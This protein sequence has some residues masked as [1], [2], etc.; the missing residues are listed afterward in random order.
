EF[1]ADRFNVNYPHYKGHFARVVTYKTEYAQS[2][3]DDFSAKD[4][5]PHIALS[6]DM[7]DTGI[8]V[9]EVV[10]LV[11]F[12]VV[13]SKTKFWQMLGRGTRLCRDLF[14]PGEDKQF[15]YLFDYCQN[16]EFFSQN[17]DHVDGAGGEALGTR[18]FKA[19]LQLVAEL[20]HRVAAGFVVAEPPPPFGAPYDDAQ[21]RSDVAGFLHQQVAAMNMDNFVVRPQRRLVEKYA[22]PQAWKTLGPDDFAELADGVADLPTEFVDDDEEAK[23][24]DL[25][26]LRTQLAI[27]QAL[28]GFD[29]LKEKIQSI[30]SALEE[31]DA[32][33][34]IKAQMVLIQSL[35]GE[36]WWEDVT[37][38][39][40]E[41]A[42]KRLRALVKL[43]EKGKKKVVYT[44][45]EDELGD[46]TAIELP[47]V[48]TGMNLAK[49]RDKARQFLKAHASH[50]SLQRLRR[51]QPLTPTDLTE[52]E[53]MLV[54][55]GGSPEVIEQ[56]KAQSHG[57]GIFIRSLVGLDS[58]TARQAFSQFVA[59]TTATASQIE[60]I[61]LVVQYL[62]ENGVMEPARLYESPFID[63]NDK[64][65]E[66]IF[67]PARVDEMVR[68]L[69]G[70]RE[71]A[72]A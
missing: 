51:N 72:V 35:V 67:L 33:P 61:D 41:T 64:G 15:F 40:L 32:I 62:T 37:V 34:A 50:V 38:A 53:R 45:F 5:A 58:E 12:K 20:D 8:D 66:A 68:V 16:L 17:P 65:P 39:M 13:R 36:E 27:L 19:R 54:Q 31:Q 69:E 2:L 9:P 52:L 28:P 29:G 71:R 55:A 49:F 14:A 11:F 10:N 63:I 7:L 1:I 4:K 22:K 59:G 26:V 18:L 23:R 6:V 24:F 21:L 30:A 56:A 3:I 70:I 48:G 25:L 57:L 43:I 42:R 47:Q 46:E 44:D 60:F